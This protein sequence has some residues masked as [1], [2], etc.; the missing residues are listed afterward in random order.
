MWMQWRP[1]PISRYPE[2]TL[3]T[4]DFFLFCYR[5]PQRTSSGNREH[6]SKAVLTIQISKP[7]I[8]LPVLSYLLAHFPVLPCDSILIFMVQQVCWPRKNSYRSHPFIDPILNSILSLVTHLSIQ[9]YHRVSVHWGVMRALPF[10]LSA[11]PELKVLFLRVN[12]F[13]LSKRSP[14]PLTNVA[15]LSTPWVGVL[16]L[17]SGM[18][19]RRQDASCLHAQALWKHPSHGCYNTPKELK[20]ELSK[21]VWDCIPPDWWKSIVLFLTTT[22]WISSKLLKQNCL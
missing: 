17:S 21:L 2:S 19:W 7:D 15:P 8:T 20:L 22:I 5:R 12:Q 3:H 4:Q 1:W 11:S 6:Q 14:A 9:Q 10:L 16:A 13:F 18:G